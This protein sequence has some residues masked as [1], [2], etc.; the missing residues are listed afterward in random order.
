MRN[1]LILGVAGIALPLFVHGG[2]AVSAQQ[3]DPPIECRSCSS[4]LNGLSVVSATNAWAVG[5][6]Q[7]GQGRSSTLLEHWDGTAWSVVGGPNVDGSS[8][9]TSVDADRSGVWVVG[10]YVETRTHLERPLIAHYDGHAWDVYGLRPDGARKAELNGVSLVSD[11]DAWAVGSETTGRRTSVVV[12][13]WDGA[14]WT[15]LAAR[16]LDSPGRLNGVTA[17]TSTDVWAVGTTQNGIAMAEHWN[18]Q[19][20][21]HLLWARPVGQRDVELLGVSAAS[22]S[23]LWAVGT[24]EVRRSGHEKIMALHWDGNRWRQAAGDNVGTYTSFD[25]VDAVSPTQAWAFGWSA[26]G[27]A[28]PSTLIEHWDGTHWSAVS[29]PGCGGYPSGLLGASGDDPSDL[30]AVGYQTTHALLVHWD[31]HNWRP[32]GRTPLPRP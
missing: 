1:S 12:A 28:G 2:N 10:S 8:T 27:P 30:W 20:W 25:A 15:R 18:G 16:G 5:W 19:G 24:Y 21:R 32:S 6:Q 23:D 22:P 26:T 14:S 13:H 31:G 17:V 4:G 7:K 29:C 11:D 3:K 9:L